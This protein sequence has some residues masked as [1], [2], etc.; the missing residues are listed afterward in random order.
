MQ[1]EFLLLQFLLLLLLL[2]YYLYLR[3]E[4]DGA[5]GEEAPESETLTFRMREGSSLIQ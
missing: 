3:L 2:L 5:W 4:G 1:R